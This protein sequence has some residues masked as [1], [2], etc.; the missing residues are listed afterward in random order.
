V[1]AGTIPMGGVRV[2]ATN[3][4]SGVSIS[5]FTDGGGAYSMTLTESGR[6]LVRAEYGTFSASTRVVLIEVSAGAQVDLLLQKASAL[7][8]ENSTGSNSISSLWPSQLLPPVSISSITMQ[9]AT[10]SAGGNSG[11]QLPSFPGDPDFSGDTFTVNGQAQ[12][13]MTFF[14][15][16]DLMRQSFEDGHE[17]QGRSLEPTDNSSG[18]PT[19]SASSVN[20]PHGVLFWTG[21]N[22]AL[23]ASP[24]VLAGQ[25]A[26]NPSYSSSGYGMAIGTKPFLPG[27]TRPSPNDFIL[28]SFAGQ[29]STN[30]VNDYGVVP[31]ALERAGNFSQFFGPSKELV[32]IYPQN[33]ATPY[34]NNTI[35]T[36]LSPEALG[37]LQYLP[38]PNLQSTGL[39]YR[40]LTTQGIHANTI[41]ATYTHS[42]SPP[43]DNSQ[44][45]NQSV[46]LNFNFG[47]I[48]SDVVN[49]F[50]KLGGRQRVQGY[51]FTAGYTA[52]IGEL[53]SNI[54]V[55]SSRNNSEIGNY[56]TNRED[57]ATSLGIFGNG[58]NAPLNPNP[59]N[60][61][62]P[63]LVLNNFN[64]MN[65][66]QPNSQLTQTLGISG[67]ASW[68]HGAHNLRFGGD[69]HRVEFNLFGG[70]NATGTFIFTGL[71]TR[72]PFTASPNPLAPTGISFA[73]FLLGI[74]QQTTIESPDQKAY[75]RQT[76]W[77]AFV[78]DDWRVLP[79]LTILAGLRYDFF[80]P[81]SEKYNRL[82]T[83]D[84]N[85]DFSDFAPVQPN[86]VGPVT[87][88]RYPKTLI[89]PDRNNFSP[90]LGFAWQATKQTVVRAA[91]EIYYTVGMYGSFIE[92]LAYQPPFANVQSNPNIFYSIPELALTLGNGFEEAS[93]LGNFAINKHYRLPYTQV[94]YL[95]VQR[96]LPLGIVL[97]VGYTG[98]KGSRLDVISAPGLYNSTGFSSGYFDF[99][100]STGF[101]NFNS[102][103]VRANK[104]LQNGIAFQA[105]YTYSH[106][107]DDASSIQA[108]SQTV[109]Q[110]WQDILAEESNSSFDI[111][112]QL[113]GSFLYQLPFGPTR[114]YLNKGDWASRVFGDWSLSSYFDLATGLPLTPFVQASI[115]EV[116]RGTHG[117]VRPNLV[118]DV[119]IRQGGGHILHW[120]NTAAFSTDFAPGQ[121]YGTASRYSIPGPGVQNVNLSLSKLIAFKD[122]RSLELRATANNALNIVQYSGV[123]TQFDSST[124]GQVNA[125]QPMR[126]LTFLARFR[127]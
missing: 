112:S 127:F 94:W 34:P 89:D 60:Y 14:Q 17:L 110:N 37:L 105:T 72:K 57:I 43:D 41:G 45:L 21:G 77:D 69:F 124:V 126:Q 102:L 83:L 68:T 1:K 11:G 109:A 81:Y 46:N 26:P 90:H 119:S 36:A 8:A 4:R 51:S 125:V 55:T 40:L 98:A 5:T 95:D 86:G 85:S 115:A 80:S 121:Q 31:T 32:P 66:T 30:L 123:N 75:A 20:Q 23:N 114:P 74:P 25:P 28:L 107:I 35:D 71:D 122:A 47:D 29:L 48:A 10:G 38:E 84:Y 27:I 100:D 117:S 22:S 93:D 104:R 2:T 63:N 24:F 56:F 76:N 78:R 70:A 67:S 103:V 50:P 108:G 62:L 33:S 97:D 111:R 113:T 106:S 87:G 92:D 7:Q 82:S 19:T 13:V 61:G 96:N 9:P 120:F 39:N 88:T 118:P 15:M 58:F 53:F 49:L 101:S 59:R 16:G 79:N 116:E 54:N 52:G 12:I 3:L 18:G 73:D 6:Y 65:E 64:G 44:G 99:E 91:Y 42:F